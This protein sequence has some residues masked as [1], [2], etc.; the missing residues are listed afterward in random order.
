MSDSCAKCGI[1]SLPIVM[2]ISTRQS[3][4]ACKKK[5]I[6]LSKK[7]WTQTEILNRPRPWEIYSSFLRFKGEEVALLSHQQKIELIGMVYCY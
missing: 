2:Y 4:T 7:K 1:K 5:L 3:T 6:E